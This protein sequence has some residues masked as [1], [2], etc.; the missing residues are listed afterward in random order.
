LEFRDDYKS[1]G[2]EWAK[3]GDIKLY[4]NE[5]DAV[6]GRRES[7]LRLLIDEDLVG[8]ELEG[9][10]GPEG[11]WKEMARHLKECGSVPSEEDAV[12]EAS[13]LLR[14]CPDA[15]LESFYTARVKGE[16]VPRRW[17]VEVRRIE[18]AAMP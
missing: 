17:T 14:S 5:A 18:D 1:R 16:S 9:G 8:F 7:L 4:G 15:E 12:S 13:L 2:E 3:L 10:Y 6:R 11:F